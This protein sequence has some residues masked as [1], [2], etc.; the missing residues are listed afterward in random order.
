MWIPGI[1]RVWLILW[2]AMHRHSSLILEQDLL[3][4]CIAVCVKREPTGQVQVR[5]CYDCLE[6]SVFID[7]NPWLPNSFSPM[8]STKCAPVQTRYNA[9]LNSGSINDVSCILCSVGA[10]SSASGEPIVLLLEVCAG[11]LVSVPFSSWRPD[12]ESLLIT[13]LSWRLV[14]SIALQ[15]LRSQQ[16]AAC[17]R[18]ERT[19]LGQVR[20]YCL[21][22]ALHIISTGAICAHIH[23]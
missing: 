1:W 17:A 15:G 10:Y 11:L 4:L 6:K 5:F 9:F 18:Q 19:G 14:L 2:Q 12:G 8:T 22:F 3:R 13:N 16:L 20:R 7:V 23:A 21:R